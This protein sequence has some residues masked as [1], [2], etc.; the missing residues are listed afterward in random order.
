MNQVLQRTVALLEEF[1][2]HEQDFAYKILIQ[3]AEFNENKRD[4]R[5]AAYV[6]KIQRGIKQC[7]EGRGI[8][9]DII[10]VEDDE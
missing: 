1:D 5:N 2:E 9:R 3:I 10:E 4:K 7:A 8:N 6:A